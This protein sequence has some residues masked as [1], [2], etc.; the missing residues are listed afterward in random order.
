LSIRLH[1][2]NKLFGVLPETRFY[3]LKA[4]LLG[5][6]GF[7]IHKTARIVSSARFWGPYEL[8]IGRDTFVGH[9]VL[10]VGGV[11]T[12]VIGDYCDIGPRV[13]V[14]AGSH[15]I[16]M[17][18]PRSAGTGYSKDIIIEGGVWIGANS[19]VLG[20]VRIGEKAVIGAGSLVTKDIPPCV[21]AVGN[22]CRP[23]KRWNQ[24]RQTWEMADKRNEYL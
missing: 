7:N 8:S 15:E 5:M 22:P 13:T 9:E 21:L 11:C 12:I 17:I 14:V 6:C 24:T 1:L 4:R 2:V 19:T 23:V 18:S 10:V 16:D 3:G 20:G